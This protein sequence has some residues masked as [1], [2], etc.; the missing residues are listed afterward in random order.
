MSARVPSEVIRLGDRNMR[1][2]A[3]ADDRAGD[4]RFDD[5]EGGEIVIHS[6][7]ALTVLRRRPPRKRAA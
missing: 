2:V 6:A 1:V 5:G 3:M 7:P 4:T